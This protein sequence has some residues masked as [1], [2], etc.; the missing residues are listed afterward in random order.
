MSKHQIIKVSPK[1][2]EGEVGGQYCVMDVTKEQLEDLAWLQG[3]VGG[4]IEV[5]RHALPE[6]LKIV[7]NEEGLLLGMKP[8][9]RLPEYNQMLVG[10]L[11]IVQDTIE[12]EFTGLDPEYLYAAQKWVE[13]FLIT[14][15]LE[16]PEPQC[17][18]YFDDD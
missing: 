2:G 18:V 8:V 17:E 4:L 14:V 10:S 9:I 15:D 11:L 5:V 3:Q 16:T 1:E 7:V 13:H 12:G 6:P